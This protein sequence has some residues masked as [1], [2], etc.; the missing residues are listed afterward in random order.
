MFEYGS[1]GSDFFFILDGEV[2]ILLPNKTRI[3]EYN[4]NVFEIEQ[5]KNSLVSKKKE[6]ENFLLI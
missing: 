4:T 5:I 1:F 3:D 2:E 6:L